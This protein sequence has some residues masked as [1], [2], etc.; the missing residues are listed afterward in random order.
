MHPFVERIN[1]CGR[2]VAAS[3]VYNGC[4]QE[5]AYYRDKRITRPQRDP[6]ERGERRTLLTPPVS[7]SLTESVTHWPDARDG[8]G[9]GGAD[10]FCSP[11]SVLARESQSAKLV[12]VRAGASVR[13]AAPWLRASSRCA[14]LRRR[15]CAALGSQ[16]TNLKRRECGECAAID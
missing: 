9:A 11:C 5:Q 10:G 13:G 3:R 6:V 14:R 12:R 4:R 8:V 15:V 16:C 2:T 1:F 7:D